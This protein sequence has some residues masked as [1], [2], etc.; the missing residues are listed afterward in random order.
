MYRLYWAQNVLTWDLKF[1]WILIVGCCTWR[2]SVNFRKNIYFVYNDPS[3]LNCWQTNHNEPH[4]HQN[5]VYCYITLNNF[6][7]RFTETTFC[8]NVYFLYISDK[9]ESHFKQVLELLIRNPKDEVSSVNE[10]LLYL[11]VLFFQE[12]AMPL[13]L[14][15]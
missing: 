13:E 10:W 1:S 4:S 12:G 6:M 3:T 15:S 11:K 14:F 2:S 5:N 9:S 8:R 7:F